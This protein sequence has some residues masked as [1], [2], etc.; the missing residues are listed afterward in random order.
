MNALIEFILL[1]VY[2]LAVSTILVLMSRPIRW[3]L[4]RVL[5]RRQNADDI[6]AGARKGGPSLGRPQITCIGADRKNKRHSHVARQGI[7]LRVGRN[8]G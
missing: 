6:E 8:G 5:E 3:V 4:R 1:T 2:A 7:E